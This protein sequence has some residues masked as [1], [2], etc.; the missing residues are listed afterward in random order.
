MGNSQEEEM[1]LC[2]FCGGEYEKK[3][4]KQRFCC[5]SCAVKW[6]YHNKPET[7]AKVIANSK[8]R[9]ARM[10]PNQDFREKMRLRAQEWY[11]RKKEKNE[12]KDAQEV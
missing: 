4:E 8:D 6:Y 10:W 11:R 7:K 5:K 1:T 12:G 2:D 3:I 9:H